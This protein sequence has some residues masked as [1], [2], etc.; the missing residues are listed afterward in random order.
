MIGLDNAAAKGAGI[1]RSYWVGA[2]NH[3]ALDQEQE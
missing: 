2:R 3:A 1:Y